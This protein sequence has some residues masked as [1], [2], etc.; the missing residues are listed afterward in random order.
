MGQKNLDHDHDIIEIQE[1]NTRLLVPSNSIKEKIPPKNPAFFNPLARLN[2]NISIL[3]YNAFLEKNNIQGDISFA[4]SLSSIGSRGLR[5][6]NEVYK[7]N[8]VYLNDVN[9][10]AIALAKRSAELNSLSDKC[11]FS[12]NEVCKFLVNPIPLFNNNQFIRS[13][14]RYTIVDLDPFGS[15]APYVDCVLRAVSNNGLISITATDTAVLCGVY[16]KVCLRKYYGKSIKSQYSNEIGIRI[17]IS[18]IALTASRLDLIVDPIFVHSNRHYLRV[19][20]KTELSSSRSNDIYN[21]LGYIRH[22]PNCGARNV[23]HE[24]NNEKCELCSNNYVIAGPLWIG[25]LFDKILV[26]NILSSIQTSSLS[27]LPKMEAESDISCSKNIDNLYSRKEIE[28]LQKL[29]EIAY[30]EIDD[31]PYY[32]SLDEIASKGKTNPPPMNIF[33]KRLH[34]T[35]YRISRTNFSQTGIKTNATIK[36]LIKEIRSNTS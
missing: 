24:Y 5:V 25:K 3:V 7:I 18:L 26:G 33:L 23:I 36:E 10:F 17:L 11:F 9:E 2:R 34:D 16:P 27:N 8:K 19:Y 20:L 28:T 32:F 4:D 31:I 35:G 22:C 1:G 15:P 6:A 21:N 29:F 14:H 12:I 30:Y 13:N